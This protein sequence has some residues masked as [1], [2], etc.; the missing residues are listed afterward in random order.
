M[1]GFSYEE[2]AAKI[3]EITEELVRQAITDRLKSGYVDPD[4]MILYADVL[5]NAY[6]EKKWTAERLKEERLKELK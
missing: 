5:K 2:K 1:K 3:A 6:D 4:E